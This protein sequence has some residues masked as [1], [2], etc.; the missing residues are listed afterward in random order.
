M[1][2]SRAAI[3]RSSHPRRKVGTFRRPRPGW[4]FQG[5]QGAVGDSE[6]CR[7]DPEKL[8]ESLELASMAYANFRFICGPEATSGP[9]CVGKTEAFFLFIHS[10]M[11]TPTSSHS[12]VGPSGAS[13]TPVGTH[14]QRNR[15]VLQARRTVVA[16]LR[17]CEH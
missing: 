7:T 16:A 8:K 12:S 15:R 9:T 11:R 14:R 13:H 5:D 2:P 1:F 3:E 10:I 17:R 4:G 6:G